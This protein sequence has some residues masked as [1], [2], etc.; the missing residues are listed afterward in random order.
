[1]E[2]KILTTFKTIIRTG[3]FSKAARRLNYTPS[4]IT[5]HVAQLEE[6]AGVRIFEKSGRRMILTQ[7]G[8]A[9]VPYVDEVLEAARKIQNFQ[10]D[11]S[12]YRGALTIGAPESM[13]CFRLPALLKRLHRQ[14][15][16]VDLRLRSLTSHDVVTALHEDTV[17][18]GFVYSVHEKDREQLDFRAFESSTAHFYASPS[19]AMRCPDMKT[20]GQTVADITR[21]STPMPG[22]I[23]ALLD[24][25]LS[26]KEITFDNTIELRGTQTIINLIE[27]DMGVALLPDFA[28]QDRVTRKA[29]AVVPSEKIHVRS[30]CG[31]RKNKWHSPAMTLFFDVLSEYKDT[32]DSC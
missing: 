29:L 4:T 24:D 1:M 18:I 11:I 13:L 28:V 6:T 31:T 27:N 2:L 19:V 26:K 25:Y 32:A 12:D 30:F 20:S 22:E 17:D 15:P 21:V 16:H 7:A 10:Y 14:A 23:R 9:L 3:S 5:F 8:E